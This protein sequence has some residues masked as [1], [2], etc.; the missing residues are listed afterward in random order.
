MPRLYKARDIYQNGQ[1][2]K[3]SSE[4]DLEEYMKIDEK[5]K[6][7]LIKLNED[8]Q[9]K[10]SGKDFKKTTSQIGTEMNQTFTSVKSNNK[11]KLRS[12]KVNHRL[13]NDYSPIKE[14]EP[15]KKTKLMQKTIFFKGNCFIIEEEI[16]DDS[17]KE[18]M[19]MTSDDSF[20]SDNEGVIEGYNETIEH[21]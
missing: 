11:A 18:S 15:K 13:Q 10:T 7:P 3:I 8:G 17:D 1:E 2:E 9:F 6:R 16:T 20:E 14:E 19:I 12:E 4:S 21:K 5:K